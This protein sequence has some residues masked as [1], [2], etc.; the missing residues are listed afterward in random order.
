M[1]DTQNPN[2]NILISLIVILTLIRFFF[3]NSDITF[4]YQS[5][6]LYD[7][8]YYYGNAINKIHDGSW[9][10]K[11]AEA[12]NNNT[13]F[14]TSS[15]YIAMNYLVAKLAGT[16]FTQFRILSV[17][18]S[19]VFTL[20]LYVYL[21]DKMEKK[22]AL[23]SVLLLNMSNS[24][25]IFSRVARPELLMLVCMFASLVLLSMKARV[26]IILS[27]LFLGLNVFFVKFNA[28]L[29][30][31]ILVLHYAFFIYENNKKGARDIMLFF[32]GFGMALVGYILF[33]SHY[34]KTFS[35][36]L[37]S[38]L[39]TNGFR[40]TNIPIG[41]FKLW[42]ADFFYFDPFL[43][44]FAIA[45]I[46][47]LLVKSPKL[48]KLSSWWIVF[49]V[50]L[51]VGI[52]LGY[53]IIRNI[54]ILP[55]VVMIAIYFL[56]QM[57]SEDFK[58]A[59]GRLQNLFMDSKIASMIRYCLLGIIV[60][61]W[62]LITYSAFNQILSG[63]VFA[64]LLAMFCTGIFVLIN[65]WYSRR[66]KI[67][68]VIMVWLEMFCIVLP[69][70]IICCWIFDIFVPARYYHINTG[71]YF[72]YALVFLITLFF[73]PYISRCISE[74][75]KLRKLLAIGL[76]VT[77]AVGLLSQFTL[78][79]DT[80]YEFTRDVSWL[81]EKDAAVF[82]AIGPT[83]QLYAP[84]KFYAYQDT[85]HGA[86]S[87]YYFVIHPKEVQYAFSPK[88]YK[89]LIERDIRCYGIMRKC[90]LR[91]SLFKLAFDPEIEWPH[92]K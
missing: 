58:D 53:I 68:F 19:I 13:R 70:S 16:G 67:P 48:I 45:A 72:S 30:L 79:E 39:E 36:L 49:V 81:V 87:N 62:I 66:I 28:L 43:Y 89:I 71:N 9:I 65:H 92:E 25:L 46:P 5:G 83:L 80:I 35:S 64:A 78:K 4:L 52:R 12:D 57:K 11:G 84:E 37:S 42:R 7:E 18:F 38:I 17:I 15:L 8:P 86:Q 33:V 59:I 3:L 77:L 6:W 74:L 90:T 21:K 51:N 60:V 91:G 50:L 47:L 82:S 2:K 76:V 27:G 40:F 20:L 32:D 61:S 75:H 63:R 69:F 88:K 29:F 1:L 73:I 56:F 26:C 41:I 55:F 31:F 24:L 54:F 14:I 10:I 85:F 23:L 44:G 22:L 34:F